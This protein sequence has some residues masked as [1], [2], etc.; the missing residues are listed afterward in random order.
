[1]PAKK[2]LDIVMPDYYRRLRE[3]MQ[4]LDAARREQLHQILAL[5]NAGIPAFTE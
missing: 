4:G 1:M 2:K 3:C 5:I